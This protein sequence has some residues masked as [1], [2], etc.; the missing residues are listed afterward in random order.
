MSRQYVTAGKAVEAVENKRMSFKGYCASQKKIGKVDFLLASETIKFSNVLNQI[1]RLADVSAKTLDVEEGMMK[2]MSY[3]LLFG[4]KKINGGGA[5]KRAIMIVHQ[6]L[7]DAR[8]E[9]MKVKEVDNPYNLLSDEAVTATNLLKYVRINEIKVSHIDQAFLEI[10]MLFPTAK[11]DTM[12][13]SLVVLPPG[14]SLGQ[15][16]LVK[17]GHL[18]I[19]DK[20]SCFPSQCLFDWWEINKTGDIIDACAAPGNKTSHVAAL[21]SRHKFSTDCKI[22]AF[23]KDPKRSKLLS[24]RML[25]AG[26]ENVYVSN[27]DFL[28]LNV[29]DEEYKSVSCILLDPSCSGSGVFRDISRVLERSIDIP[30]KESGRLENLRSFQVAALKKAMLFP[31]VQCVVYS[32]CSIFTEENESVVA[33]ILAG[34]DSQVTSSTSGASCRW[35][36]SDLP[37]RFQGWPRRGVEHAG[38]SYAQQQQLLRC[39]PSD[40]LNGFFVAM[41]KKVSVVDSKH[42][43]VDSDVK[44]LESVG[45]I[46]PSIVP[47]SNKRR[48]SYDNAPKKKKRKK[49]IVWKSLS[50]KN[51]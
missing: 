8:D 44:Y 51:Y 32:T 21:V 29:H 12:I 19:Q 2:V 36:L 24:D 10:K 50:K 40:G 20:A 23:D 31:A 7:L 4:R 14:R 34:C 37:E 16:P 41:F 45:T 28:S 39:E 15:H 47:P 38:L 5:V 13:P 42:D 18:I 30:C 46:L 48:I 1:F 3:E 26:A 25:Q 43:V 33:E 11:F 6:K 17:D 27:A 35:T 49:N 9:L 22:F